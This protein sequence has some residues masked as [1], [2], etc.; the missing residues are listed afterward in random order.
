GNVVSPALPQS[1]LRQNDFGGTIGGPIWKDRTF[2]FFSYEGLRLLQPATLSGFYFTSQ[3]KAAV[4]TSS[5]WY[6]IVQATPTGPAPNPSGS[7]LYQPCDNVN[8]P[9]E[10]LLAVSFS[11]PSN[12][13]SYSLRLDQKLTD[14]I[15]VFARYGHTPSTEG[16]YSPINVY[17]TE[18]QNT[19]MATLGL[20]ASI[21]PTMVNDFRGNW[22]R[23]TSGTSYPFLP[24]YGA[25]KAPNSALFP[26][27]I[28]S[29]NY[30]VQYSICAGSCSEEVVTGTQSGETQRQVNLIDNVSKSIGSHQ[31]KFGV[32]YRRLMATEMAGSNLE[33]IVESWQSIQNGTADYLLNYTAD[34][35]SAHINNIGLFAQDTWKATSHL[36][37]TYGLRWDI[38]PAPVSDSAGKPLYALNGVFNSGPLAL[39][40]RSIW[41]TDLAAFAPR[42][43]A[44]YQITPKTVVRA[45]F[46]LFYDL[47]FGFG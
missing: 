30:L 2:F 3:A 18:W 32:D 34:Q 20:T 22:S 11:N 28:N 45:G 41:N 29:G 39:E 5:P 15:S 21:S 7:N 19:D 38:N 24:L 31:L 16:I 40:K 27:S 9:C 23:Q 13:N 25:V 6:P 12:F 8:T 33:P 26:S 36:T 44:A 4:P 17:E 43:G 42:V 10:T 14:K 46:G 35:I 47:G 37:L 1:P